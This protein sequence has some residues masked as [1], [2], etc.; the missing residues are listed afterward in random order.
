MT[1]KRPTNNDVG[2]GCLVAYNIF[3][4]F[5]FLCQRF[6]VQFDELSLL[7]MDWWLL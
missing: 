7:K 2:P 3:K 5:F 6:L 1:N 4:R